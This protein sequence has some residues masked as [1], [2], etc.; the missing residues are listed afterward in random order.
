MRNAIAHRT[1]KID[2]VSG[3]ILFYDLEKK[4]EMSFLDL[5]KAT[6]ELSANLLILAHFP[7]TW[8]EL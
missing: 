1:F 8:V 3:S 7:A 6:R 2:L 4:L 5:Q